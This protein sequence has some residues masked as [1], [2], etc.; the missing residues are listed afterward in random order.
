MRLI[1]IKR[2]IRNDDCHKRQ[3]RK[4]NEYSNLN[5]YL[6]YVIY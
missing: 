2:R 1:A 5:Q 4:R 6:T 3:C